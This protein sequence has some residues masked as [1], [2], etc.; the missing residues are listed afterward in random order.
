[1]NLNSNGTK[2]SMRVFTLDVIQ[3]DFLLFTVFQFTY[4]I[5]SLNSKNLIYCSYN[6][7]NI[8][9]CPRFENN[10]RG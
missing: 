3:I 9:P 1:M 8:G 7:F 2:L 4:I 10:Q 5:Y 6:N